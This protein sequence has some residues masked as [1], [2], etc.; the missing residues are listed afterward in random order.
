MSGAYAR[1]GGGK[2]CCSPNGCMIVHNNNVI[3]SEDAILSAEIVESGSPEPRWGSSQRSPDLLAGGRGLAVPSLRTSP[4]SR[5][6]AS[7]FGHSFLAPNEQ[8]SALR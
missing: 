1:V 7:I 3:V 6:L 4:R 2:G 5:P 8:S